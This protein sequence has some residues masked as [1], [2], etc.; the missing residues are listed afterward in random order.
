MT[1]EPNPYA[2]PTTG[3]APGAVGVSLGTP[4]QEFAVTNLQKVPWTLALYS[5]HLQLAP[6]G[7][8]QALGRETFDRQ[9]FI[10]R[11]TLTFL[12]KARAQ[13]RVTKVAPALAFVLPP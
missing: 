8:Q 5:A 2:P 13:L 11:T 7:D 10:D 1:I 12:S 4:L 6:V 9:A 3:A